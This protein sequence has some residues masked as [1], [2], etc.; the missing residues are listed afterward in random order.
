MPG[1]P[2]ATLASIAGASTVEAV[3]CE[4]GRI[5]P[6]SL[7][8]AS[9][10]FEAS[11]VWSAI[12][13]ADVVARGDWVGFEVTQ[14]ARIKEPVMAPVQKCSFCLM[15]LISLGVGIEMAPPLEPPQNTRLFLLYWIF[16]HPLDRQIAVVAGKGQYSPRT[17]RVAAI[18]MNTPAWQTG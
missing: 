5:E 7:L 17:G 10:S 11:R 4:A 18:T 12:C 2:A 9:E 14:P 8:G 6:T 3:W 13:G 15:W 16:R 1:V